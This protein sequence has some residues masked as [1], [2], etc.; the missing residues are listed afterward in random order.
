MSWWFIYWITRIN[1]IDDFFEVV[2]GVSIFFCIIL[3]IAYC[4]SRGM[5]ADMQDD[6][7]SG[8]NKPVKLWAKV[9]GIVGSVCIILAILTPNLKEAAAIY[10]IPK[11][12]NNE[13]VQ[14]LPN[15]ATKLLRLKLDE[16]INDPTKTTEKE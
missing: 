4:V 13:N 15:D 2:G 11:I 5:S 12:V 9:C 16:W 7:Y 3:I 8:F 6:E 10:L 1:A 14:E